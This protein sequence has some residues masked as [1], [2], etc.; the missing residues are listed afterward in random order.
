MLGGEGLQLPKSHGFCCLFMIVPCNTCSL[1]PGPRD[2]YN[3]TWP[4]NA[5]WCGIYWLDRCASNKCACVLYTCDVLQPWNSNIIGM[6]TN[7]YSWFRSK[8][9]DTFYTDPKRGSN[10]RLT[11][12][13]LS[14]M[15]NYCQHHDCPG[16]I[17]DQIVECLL[18]KS[19]ES[20]VDITVWYFFPFDSSEG[21]YLLSN[22]HL[23]VSYHN[24]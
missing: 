14:Q 20:D 13:P 15:L 23:S 5:I 8:N 24:V 10:N 16:V 9:T 18:K 22:S 19:C 1:L 17:D 3:I 12:T 6:S 4:W 21:A 7:H 11:G 2:R